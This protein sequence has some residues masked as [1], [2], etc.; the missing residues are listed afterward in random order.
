MI[1]KSKEKG[2]YCT[3]IG[4]KINNKNVNVVSYGDSVFFHFKNEKLVH[5]IPTNKSSDLDNFSKFLNTKI[6]DDPN[7]FEAEYFNNSNFE[8]EDG[9]VIILASDAFSKYILNRNDA[10]KE[11]STSQTLMSFII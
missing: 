9:D 5:C 2:S 1:N 4:V 6:L 7:F 11:L 3:F 10:I 8:I